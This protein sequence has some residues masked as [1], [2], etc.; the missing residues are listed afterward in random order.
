[1][2]CLNCQSHLFC[3]P[4]HLCF[5]LQDVWS[6]PGRHLQS[7]REKLSFFHIYT[8]GKLQIYNRFI[9][10]ATVLPDRSCTS[11]IGGEKKLQEEASVTSIGYTYP[12]LAKK[13]SEDFADNPWQPLGKTLLKVKLWVWVTYKIP[14]NSKKRSGNKANL[15]YYPPWNYTL[16]V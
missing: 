2:S 6:R 15:R 3:K 10:D 14:L 5:C 1:M 16:E 9:V 4:L 11:D 13:R 8:T 12:K 7:R